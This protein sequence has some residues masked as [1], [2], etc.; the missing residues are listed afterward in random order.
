MGFITAVTV[1]FVPSSFIYPLIVMGKPTNLFTVPAFFPIM[2]EFTV[3][4]SAFTATFGM[5]IMNGL[6]KLNHPMFNWERFKRASE[7]KFFCVVEQ[8]DPKFAARE[9]TSSSRHSADA[10]SPWCTRTEQFAGQMRS[11]I[12]HVSS[13]RTVFFSRLTPSRQQKFDEIFLHLHGDPRL[14]WLAAPHVRFLHNGCCSGPMAGFAGKSRARPPIEIFPD[15][16]RQPKGEGANTE[17]VLRRWT[18]RT[19]AGR[20]DRAAGLCNA[21]AQAGGRFG[22]RGHRPIQQIIFSSSPNYIDTGKMGENWGTGLPFEVS[23]RSCGAARSDL[24]SIAPS[25]T[26][27]PA[28]ETAWRKSLGSIPCKACFRIAFGPCPTARSST[29]SPTGRTR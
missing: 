21:D 28:Q 29:R 4:I 23:S 14:P 25:V 3:L 22:G 15:M 13:C 10:T 27:R 26:A 12:F 6:P 17:R 11:R 7:D 16:D 20:G 8:S 19:P 2:F 5:L 24:E 1:Q 9:V 18:R